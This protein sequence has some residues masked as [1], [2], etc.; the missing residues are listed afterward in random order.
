MLRGAQEPP[1]GEAFWRIQRAAIMRKVHGL[2]EPGA[3]PAQVRPRTTIDDGRSWLTWAPALVAA[4][5]VVVV[6]ALR[7]EPRPP[8]GS[9]VATTGIESLDDP[10][11]M[12]LSDLAGYSS[13]EVDQ[14]AEVVEEMGPLPELTNAELDALAELVGVRER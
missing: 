12:S 10:T 14:T 4:M 9:G 5:A 6:L 3:H 2:P 13:P 1:L 7:L 11:L 8:V